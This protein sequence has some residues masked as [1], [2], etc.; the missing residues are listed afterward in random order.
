M[1]T[2]RIPDCMALRQMKILQPEWPIIDIDCLLF[3]YS[4]E[5]V[6]DVRETGIEPEIT[7]IKAGKIGAGLEDYLRLLHTTYTDSNTPNHPRI[8][9]T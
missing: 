7:Y 9:T 5:F 1:V 2:N 8:K 6:V 3:I 4:W